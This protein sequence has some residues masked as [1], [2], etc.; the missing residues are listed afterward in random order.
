MKQEYITKGILSGVYTYRSENGQHYYKFDYI[1]QDNYWLVQIISQPSYNELDSS[2]P[3][4]HRIQDKVGKVL[5]K[6]R[7][8]HKVD[9]LP[10]AQTLSMFW[11]EAT[12]SYILTGQTIDS[13]ISN[14]QNHE[15]KQSN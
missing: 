7:E 9:T 4:T 5:I 13:Q 12:T 14:H 1:P 10:K 6:F 11:A 8:P 2:L 15:K 3:I